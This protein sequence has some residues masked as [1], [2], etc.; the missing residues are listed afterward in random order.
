MNFDLKEIEKVKRVYYKIKL[1]KHNFKL[2]DTPTGYNEKELKSMLTEELID[3]K[4]STIKYIVKNNP[5]IKNT[6]LFGLIESN[7]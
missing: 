4:V 5:I 7:L 6:K 3:L 1:N 2:R